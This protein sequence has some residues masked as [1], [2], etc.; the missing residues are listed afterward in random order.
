MIQSA[1]LTP[2]V[3]VDELASIVRKDGRERGAVML[4][5]NRRGESFFVTV[6]LDNK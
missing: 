3:S 6:P 1:N 4:Q 2:V 5:V